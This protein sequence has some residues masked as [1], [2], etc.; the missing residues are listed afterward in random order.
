[1]RFPY[2]P[3]FVSLLEVN[4]L[5]FLDF[6]VQPPHPKVARHLKKWVHYPPNSSH[7]ISNHPHV[8]KVHLPPADLRL[9]PR[10]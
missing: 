10:Q 8:P 9:G 5:N 3:M 7:V 2:F 1:M 6:Y 4:L